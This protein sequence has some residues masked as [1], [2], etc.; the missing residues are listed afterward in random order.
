MN[1]GDSYIVF[2]FGI[3]ED[4]A[5]SEMNTN[6]TKNPKIPSNSDKDFSDLLSIKIFSGNNKYDPIN[7]LPSKSTIKIGRSAN[8]DITINDNLLSRI[9]CTI[10]HRNNFGWVIKD[11]NE[12]KN[13]D[14]TL[15]IKRSTNGTWMYAMEECVIFEGMV[16]KTNHN[17]FECHYLK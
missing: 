11:G 4:A 3:E 15:D 16:F 12:V 6:C 13:K 9:H 5:M 17:L 8:C 10:E 7:F 2:A 1:I 14:G